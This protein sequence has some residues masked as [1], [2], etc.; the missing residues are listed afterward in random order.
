MPVKVYSNDSQH[1]C[2]QRIGKTLRVLYL[3]IQIKEAMLE[4]EQM[5]LL[6]KKSRTAK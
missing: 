4:Y 1:F 3:N 2:Q 5:V 6:S